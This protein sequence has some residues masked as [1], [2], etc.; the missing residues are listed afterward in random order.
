MDR[1]TEPRHA[2][3]ANVFQALTARGFLIGRRHAPQ[4]I[5]FRR[6]RGDRD[7]IVSF[8]WDTHGRPRFTLL[9]CG[10]SIMR[11]VGAGI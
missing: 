10:V 9:A 11:T 5:D 2:L 3:R 6:T 8:Q 7:D 4:F 1:T